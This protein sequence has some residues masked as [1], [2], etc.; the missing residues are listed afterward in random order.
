[1][2]RRT[3]ALSAVLAA[4]PLGSRAD[5]YPSRPIKLLVG[6]GAGG[7]TDLTARALAEP[8]GAELKQNVIV[9][10]R[11][12]AGGNI[13]SAELARAAPDGYTLM[14][15]SPGQ[16]VVN[17]LTQKSLGFDRNTVFTPIGL[18]NTSPFVMVVPANSRFR[19]A[20]ELLE[21]GRKN[22]G[23]LTFASPGIGTT[24]HIGGEMLNAVANIQ[25]VHV[26]YRGGAQATADL[27]AGRVDFMIDSFG[28][29]SGQVGAGQ[30]RVLAAAGEKRLPQFPDLPALS[31]TYPEVVLSSWLGVVGPPNLPAPVT[32]TLAAALERAVKSR[33]YVDFV[34]TRGSSQADPRPE[35]FAAHLA[36]EKRRIE[37]TVVQRGLQLD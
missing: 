27:V 13:A 33:N 16:L 26:P 23:K 4:L 8:F 24:M 11:T 19:S 36:R 6:F 32:R 25:A 15:A 34:V 20:A 35:A 21:F 9:E 31:E 10:N 7:I 1:M 5:T 3:F 29:V 30:L 22:P 2:H 12:G 28:A 18:T 17:P 37:A 14:L